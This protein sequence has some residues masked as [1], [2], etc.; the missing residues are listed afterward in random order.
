MKT[1]PKYILLCL[2]GLYL[3][4]FVP[5]WKPILFGY[6][7]ALASLP[8]T[9]YFQAHFQVNARRFRRI[10]LMGVATFI[11]IFLAI[12]VARIF[13]SMRGAMQNPEP[14]VDIYNRV[15]RLPT[16]IYAILAERGWVISP[17]QRA[18]V[19]RQLVEISNSLGGFLKTFFSD[20]IVSA[21]ASLLSLFVFCLSYVGFISNYAV[22][23]R[24]LIHRG[25]RQFPTRRLIREFKIAS[26][27]VLG[28]TILI[29]AFQSIVTAA[30]GSVVRG[31]PFF[32]MLVGTFI[33]ALVPFGG[34]GF[35]N[36]ILALESAVNGTPLQAGVFVVNAIFVGTFDNV[37]R[38]WLTSRQSHTN[39]LFSLISI[40]GS[41]YLFGFIGIIFGPMIEHIA[42]AFLTQPR[43]RPVRLEEKA[44]AAAPLRQIVR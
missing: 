37:L 4:T 41:I 9:R 36:G 29:A 11:F 12:I 25:G 23:H 34:G 13:D 27:D 22:F 16:K 24:W 44:P 26:T 8:I 42:L 19:A 30:L 40:L 20:V 33:I 39:A 31:Y 15:L 17:E 43:E 7:C 28:T 1:T 18:F 35:V 38:A 3:L 21:P 2:A 32:P 6:I 5:F 14:Y 10:V